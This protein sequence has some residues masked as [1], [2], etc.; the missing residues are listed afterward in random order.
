MKEI[1]IFRVWQSASIDSNPSSP[2]SINRKE[3]ST[4]KGRR[5]QS[6]PSKASPE[7]TDQREY[8]EEQAQD[9][10]AWSNKIKG[11]VFLMRDAARVI[12]SL[13][14]KYV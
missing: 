2:A 6:Y 5:K 14:V 12:G 10:T 11:K 3:A 1:T 7:I 13:F 8:N 4:T 9:F